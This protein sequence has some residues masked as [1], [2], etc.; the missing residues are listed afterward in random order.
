MTPDEGLLCARRIRFS[1]F[2]PIGEAYV[3]ELEDER[4]PAKIV[5]VP[6]GRMGWDHVLDMPRREMSFAMRRPT[7]P[8]LVVHP[9][10]LFGMAGK[11]LG[12]MVDRHALKG[13]SGDSRPPE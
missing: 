3:L 6:T 4:E 7:V 10:T 8:T 2:V 11:E 5:E 9:E 1:R 13:S 12:E